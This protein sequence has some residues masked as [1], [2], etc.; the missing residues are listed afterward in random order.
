MYLFNISY[1][2]LYVLKRLLVT[3]II[4]QH[5]ALC[6]EYRNMGFKKGHFITIS[7]YKSV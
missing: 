1:P 3:D 5:D 7:Q 4:H 2:V 6:G